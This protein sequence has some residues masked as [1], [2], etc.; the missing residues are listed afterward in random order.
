MQYLNSG[1]YPQNL[2]KYPAKSDF[3]DY[4]ILDIDYEEAPDNGFE[5]VVC[6][7]VAAVFGWTLVFLCKAFEIG[8]SVFGKFCAFAFVL[9]CRS[10]HM[11]LAAAWSEWVNCPIKADMN[12]SPPSVYVETNVHSNGGNVHVETNIFLNK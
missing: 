9:I 7:A 10:V 1:N 2:R 8:L 4:E 6:Q 5:V 11:T 3:E 12:N